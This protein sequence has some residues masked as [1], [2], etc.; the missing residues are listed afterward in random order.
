[1]I[2][3]ITL[4]GRDLA[5]VMAKISSRLLMLLWTGRTSTHRGAADSQ[6]PSG[7]KNRKHSNRYYELLSAS[8]PGIPRLSK[9]LRR[10]QR[11]QPPDRL[12]GIPGTVL[13][14][15]CLKTAGIVKACNRSRPLSP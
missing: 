14:K 15:S 6:K 1:M 12:G 8:Q 5:L 7:I 2:L 11:M 13:Y 3:I 10:T 4:P 9:M